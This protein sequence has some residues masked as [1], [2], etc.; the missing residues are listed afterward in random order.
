MLLLSPAFA[1]A[2]DIKTHSPV[3][4]S[5][6]HKNFNLA[7]IFWSINDRALI[8]GMHDPCDKFFQLAPC[9]DLDL[10]LL[11]GQSCCQAGDHNSLNLLVIFGHNDRDLKVIFGIHT[12]LNEPFQMMTGSLLIVFVWFFFVAPAKQTLSTAL[13]I[14]LFVCHAFLLVALFFV[15]LVYM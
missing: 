5:V 12:P 14:H 6:R 2:G 8:F 9:H 13:S 3:C 1:K 15:Y 7:H 4:L 10:Y 11:Q